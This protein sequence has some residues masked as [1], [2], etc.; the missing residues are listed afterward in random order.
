MYEASC[1]Q[2]YS[3]YRSTKNYKDPNYLAPRIADKFLISLL[4]MVRP[5]H[6]CPALMYL[7]H[8]EPARQPSG[9]LGKTRLASSIP[10]RYFSFLDANKLTHGFSNV[11]F[12]TQTLYLLKG[13]DRREDN[14]VSAHDKHV[15]RKLKSM[16]CCLDALLVHKA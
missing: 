15:I 7:V 16:T 8:K 13:D 4:I 5:N 6:A 11:V 3:Q 12:G 9:S 14:Y 10:D 1:S 2:T